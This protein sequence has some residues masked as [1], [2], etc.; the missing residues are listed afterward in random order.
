MLV[1]VLPEIRISFT[2]DTE[3]F[4]D[5]PAGDFK[6]VYWLVSYPNLDINGE[7]VWR[8]GEFGPAL[9]KQTLGRALRAA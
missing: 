4:G 3:T 7:A 6:T 9:G 1:N 2:D 5:I 8:D